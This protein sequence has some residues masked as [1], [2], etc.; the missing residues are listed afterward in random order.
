MTPEEICSTH[1]SDRLGDLAQA[2]RD[3]GVRNVDVH[4]QL[5]LVHSFAQITIKGCT[6]H[7]FF[8]T[9]GGGF[10]RTVGWEETVA[11]CLELQPQ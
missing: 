2:L 8:S 9:G 6:I 7:G 5:V 1:P 4:P 10:F 3:E 11:M